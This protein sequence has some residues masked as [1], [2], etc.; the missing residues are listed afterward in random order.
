MTR[1]MRDSNGDLVKVRTVAGGCI[2]TR[3][4][5]PAVYVSS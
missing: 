5:R 3:R 4:G 1:I 2:I